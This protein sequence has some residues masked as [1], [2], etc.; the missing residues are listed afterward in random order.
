MAFTAQDVKTL[1]EQTGC[2]T[3]SLQHGGEGLQAQLYVVHC[4][5][6][7]LLVLLHIL[8][9]CQRQTLHHGQQGLEIAVHSGGLATDQLGN[10]RVL[11]L[12]HDGRTGCKGIV[13]FNELELP[14][15]PQD[16]LL[17]F[18]VPIVA[19]NAVASAE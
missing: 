2:G 7:R 1:R 11:L 19:A 18:P 10:I 6:D 5:E 4:V 12:G 13:Q 9:V 14:G 15:T 3:H 17:R 16:D 8:V